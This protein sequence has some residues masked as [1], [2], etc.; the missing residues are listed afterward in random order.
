MRLPVC[1]VCLD[2]DHTAD[3][4]LHSW[5]STLIEALEQNVLAM[6]GYITDTTKVDIDPERT[7]TFEVKAHDI[8]SLVFTL[9]DEFL[10]RFATNEWIPCDVRIQSLD[11]DQFTIRVTGYGER[12]TLAKHPQGTEIKA[13]T[14]SNMQIYVDGKRMRGDNDEITKRTRCDT[15]NNG[16]EPQSEEAEMNQMPANDADEGDEEEDYAPQQTEVHGADVYVIVDI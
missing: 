6:F 4:Q 12:F 11:L 2:L 14:Y 5:G 13:I 1:C 7:D 16:N 9:L 3:I 8:E 10:Y 15:D